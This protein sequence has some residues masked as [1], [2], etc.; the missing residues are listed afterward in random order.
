MAD[1]H[2]RSWDG[3]CR[4]TPPDS[5][6]DMEITRCSMDRSHGTGR[7]RRGVGSSEWPGGS[8]GT[9]RAARSTSAAR[10]AGSCPTDTTH[11]MNRPHMPGRL[12]VLPYEGEVGADLPCA[13]E[14]AVP[15]RAPASP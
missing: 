4:F 5:T 12:L 8:S 15:G 10:P 1:R 7:H 6:T 11:V 9:G 2:R 13:D 3:G 14:C